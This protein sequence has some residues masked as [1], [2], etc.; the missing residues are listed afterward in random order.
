MTGRRRRQGETGQG[1]DR[2]TDVVI[3][4]YPQLSDFP[5]TTR[6]SHLNLSRSTPINGHHDTQ[7]TI[8]RSK[9]DI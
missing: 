2:G 8:I 6:K 4:H 5:S 9:I 1:K 3:N 7:M